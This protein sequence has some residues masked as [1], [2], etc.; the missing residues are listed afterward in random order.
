MLPDLTVRQAKATGKPYTLADT[1]GLSLFVSATGAK[2]WHFRFSWGG[3]R[4]RMSAARSVARSAS[5]ACLPTRPAAAR[6]TSPMLLSPRRSSPRS[7]R[8]SSPSSGTAGPA[9]TGSL[10]TG[11]R[12]SVSLVDWNRCRHAPSRRETVAAWLVGKAGMT[13]VHQSSR[14]SIWHLSTSTEPLRGGILQGVDCSWQ[15]GSITRF[16][17]RRHRGERRIRSSRV[18]AWSSPTCKTATVCQQ[19]RFGRNQVW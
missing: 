6:R 11:F 5:G 1:D 7:R 18:R 3:K 9:R 10:V 13:D 19:T 12:T 16:C 17:Y 15:D 2:A 4:D 8:V 14:L